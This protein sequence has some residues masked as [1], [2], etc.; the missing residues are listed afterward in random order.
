VS[1][2][3]EAD[4]SAVGQ[5]GGS[6]LLDRDGVLLAI[7]A[8]LAA[9]GTGSSQALLLVGHGGMGKTRLYEAAVQSARADGLRVV[10]A[11]GAE[12]EQNLAFGVAAQLVRSLL[13][14]VSAR[15]RRTLMAEVPGRVLSLGRASEEGLAEED[16]L[17]VSH[18]I[19][20]VLAA[21]V[22]R[23]PALVAI[24]DVHWCDS[25]SLEL[26]LYLLHRLDELPAALVMTRRPAG[27]ESPTDPLTHISAHPKVQVEHLPPLGREAI[28]ALITQALGPDVD[29]GL[30]DVCR[31]ATAGNPFFVQE[32]L[33][34]LAEDPNLTPEQLTSRARS[35]VPEAVS[36]SLRVRVGRLGHEAAVLART[37]AVLGDDVPL[38]HAAVLSGLTIAQASAGADALSASDILVAR[39]P[40]RFVHPLVRQAIEQ[41]IPTS[42]RATRHLEAARLLYDEGAGVERVAAHLLLGRA[43]G[44]PWVVERLR[45]AARESRA[46]AAPQS[47]VRY[48]ER[49]LAEPP[50]RSE[51]SV[52]LGE[53][54]AA[55][56][57]LGLAGAAEHLAAAIAG[58]TDARH[59]AELGLEVGRAYGARGEHAHAAQAFEQGLRDLGL[60]FTDAADRELR[61]QLEAGFI[62][63]G[64]LV[65][66]MRPRAAEQAELWLSDVPSAPTTQGRR[67]LLAHAAL[68]AAHRGDPADRIIDFADRAW[69]GGRIL[70][71]AASQW[72]GWRIVANALY[73]AGALERAVEVGEAAIQDAR[74]RSSPL[75]FATATFTRAS[76]LM[77]QGRINDALADLEATRDGRR[78][79][80]AEFTRAAAAKYSLCLIETDQLDAA[81]AVLTEDAPLEEPFDL[82]D[83]MRLAALAEVRRLQGRLEEGLATAL[84]AG[85]AAEPVIPF[86]DYARWRTT[87]AQA[88]IGLENR[89]RAL[90]LGEEMLA[91]A[92]QTDVAERRMEALRVLGMCTGG[93]AGVEKLHQ[94]AE[95]ARSLP[96]RLETTRTLVELGAALRRSGERTASRAPLQEAADLAR[97][98]GALLL[99]HRARTELAA[100]GARPRRELLLSGPASL[101][102]S[103]RRIAELAA[104]GQSNREI[105]TML[106]VTPKTVEYHLRNAYRKLDI[107]TRRELGEALAG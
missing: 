3:R 93:E 18:G 7:E 42:E 59:R 69:D 32:L 9:A 92:E 101:T 66:S 99:Y 70:R 58:T 90:E 72:I 74:R 11:A 10:H 40:L 64:T 36:R 51:R 52:V 65:P 47:A 12:L 106:F 55:E 89:G 88:S 94:A 5:P 15:Q 4:N 86:F 16:H 104:G 84:A 34:A 62:A 14:E 39:E 24:D 78:Y 81:E 43:Q 49:A 27:D 91:R 71:E 67:L 50:A 44:D 76:P 107:Q 35:L 75:G 63:I 8:S 46:S 61:D 37:V 85:R 19:F 17:A 33:R 60:E 20:A 53:L 23:A 45:A 97:R 28:A 48:L 41:D 21:A 105:A 22:E 83:A 80:W 73:S 13:T 29:P 100:S 82:E 68:E 96:P 102:P 56:A 1:V 2:Q 87:A 57:A 79:G 77:L 31:E 95:L 38:R 98:G 25:A 6:S 26:V 103:E 30:A 54:G